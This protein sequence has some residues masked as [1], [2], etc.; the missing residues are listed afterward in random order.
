MTSNTDEVE[1]CD[2]NINDSDNE[3]L[4]NY[5]SHRMFA[6]EESFVEVCKNKSICE[7]SHPIHYDGN[8]ISF[9]HN[10]NIEQV[11]INMNKNNYIDLIEQLLH[12]INIINET[13]MK[14]VKS[15]YTK[16][17]KLN[18]LSTRYKELFN[19]YS[20]IRID[21]QMLKTQSHDRENKLNELETII[22]NYSEE[23]Y[24]LNRKN[25]EINE[26]IRFNR[27]SIKDETPK[28]Y[29]LNTSEDK[30][31]DLISFLKDQVGFYQEVN[32][33]MTK[34][35]NQ[36]KEIIENLKNVIESKSN[37]ITELN[38]I[39]ENH[40]NYIKQLRA[41]IDKIKSEKLSVCK[42]LE[43]LKNEKLERLQ[44]IEELK[45]KLN[46]H[47]GKITYNILKKYF[48]NVPGLNTKALHRID[49]EEISK[50]KRNN[51]K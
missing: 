49:I 40:N 50:K 9:S 11:D 46:K 4:I 30:D 43:I 19:C 1:Y 25:R 33:Q 3:E 36:L 18:L 15:N 44:F 45:N 17:E 47:K 21:Y 8:E 39:L 10:D 37:K 20:I 38:L 41:S 32:M 48:Y 34:D 13:L 26:I 28:S 5:I 23:V 35:K 16:N 22:K 24:N 31:E 2:I 6:L 7:E 42:E 14:V 51:K 12:E 27:N 29:I